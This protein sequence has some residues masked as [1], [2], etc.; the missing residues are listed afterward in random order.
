MNLMLEI[1]FRS[2]VRKGYLRIL[3][4]KNEVSVF[5]SPAAWP[6]VTLRLHDS[7]LPFQLMGDFVLALGEA[8]MDGRFTIE[9]GTLYD[10]L[11]LLVMNYKDAPRTWFERVDQFFAP[12][13]RKLQQYN[14]IP[15]AR[16]NVAHHYDLSS[17][18]YKL[19][20]DKDMQYSCAY[21]RHPDDDLEEAQLEKKRHIAAKLLLRPGMRVLDIGC[22]WGGMGL[23]LAKNHGVEV[24]GLTLSEEQLKIATERA[25]QEGLAQKV[26]F[27]LRDYREED[28]QYDR[29]V[30][31]GM[32]EHVGVN[33]Y[34]EFFAKVQGLLKHDGIMLLHSIGRME[35]PGMTN[36]WMRKYIFPGAYA[37]ALSEVFPAIEKKGL[38]AMD[39][40]ILRIHYAET[41]RHWWMRFN[42][43]RGVISQ[44]YD[45]RFCRMWEFYLRGCEVHF[46]HMNLMVFQIQVAKHIDA[47]PIIRDYMLEGER[48]QRLDIHRIYPTPAN[49]V[50]EPVVGL[51]SRFP[52]VFYQTTAHRFNGT[53]YATRR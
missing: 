14:P 23:Y 2:W 1:V 34:P 38:W 19:F 42:E 10:L 30:S 11:D 51:S 35:E 3:D 39:M 29:I 15:R 13:L 47:V 33:H 49:Q 37:P 16:K 28:G 26:K 8:Y 52:G 6:K 32:F 7:A 22:G 50:I 5:G 12:M 24:V 44:I 9:Q 17:K 27:Y 41:L 25:Q 48:E 21:F 43:N 20:L 40:E 46:R 31:V 18:L 4:T 36:R 53:H 45:E